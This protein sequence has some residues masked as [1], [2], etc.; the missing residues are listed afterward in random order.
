MQRISAARAVTLALGILV[1]AYVW[2]AAQRG[3]DYNTPVSVQGTV[4]WKG[5]GLG[6]VTVSFQ[7]LGMSAAKAV[8]GPDGRFVASLV[9]PGAY[10][11]L[12][13]TTP[14]LSSTHRQVE[15]RPGS[16]EIH[17]EL[18]PTELRL[19][20]TDGSG[21][22]ARMAGVYLHGPAAETTWRRAGWVS[23][24]GMSGLRLMGLGFG[25]YTAT[26]YADG[27]GLVS[28]SPGRFTLSPSVTLASVTLT[29]V[30]RP[31][32]LRVMDSTGRTVATARAFSGRR[33]LPSP[34][35]GVFVL[36]N[37]PGGEEV[38]VYARGLLPACRY[39][40]DDG[41][42]QEVL[43]PAQSPSSEAR[44]RLI[45]TDRPLGLIGGLAGSECDIGIQHFERDDGSVGSDGGLTMTL[46]GLPPGEY[47]YRAEEQ[48]A[49]VTV[50]VPGPEISYVV[51]ERCKSC[52]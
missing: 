37:V 12:L 27:D 8:T 38:T 11:M 15:L 5:R 2:T 3:R 48:E 4:V 10:L 23:E 31:L 14:H 25:T 9:D 47:S 36:D 44:F 22:A 18:P 51:P 24:A 29:L 33:S 17:W 20:I 13:Y 50:R 40:Q 19:T 6:G 49:P 45:N 35:D 30:K 21:G 7:Q 28:K 52:G 43:L 39:V 32:R 42:L 46:K 1:A 26:S 41:G 16:N 34:E